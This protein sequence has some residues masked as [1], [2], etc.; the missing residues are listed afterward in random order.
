MRSLICPNIESYIKVHILLMCCYCYI[1]RK[2]ITLKRLMLKFYYADKGSCREVGNSKIPISLWN[3]TQVHRYV[4]SKWRSD[5]KK[6]YKL[7]N[8]FWSYTKF[9]L[10]F[11]FATVSEKKMF[12]YFLKSKSHKKRNVSFSLNGAIITS[13]IHY[14]CHIGWKLTYTRPKI[15][16]PT[17]QDS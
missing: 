12:R 11:F 14:W 4:T 9:E 5:N 10:L 8:S 3:D 2:V 17:N 13:H 15:V 16:E 1:R 6:L 7:S